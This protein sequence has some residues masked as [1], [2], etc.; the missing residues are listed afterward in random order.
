MKIST[1]EVTGLFE[2]Y[3]H[4]LEFNIPK[5]KQ[6]N[7]KASVIMMYGRNGI[8]KT[9]VLRMIEGL[10]TLDFDVFRSTKFVSAC[11]TFSNGNK[12]TVEC[13]FNE[14]NKDSL[15]VRYKDMEVKLNSKERGS[16]KNDEKEKQAFFVK[17]YNQ[18]LDNFTFEFI[19]TER[20]IKRNIKEQ[21][22]IEENANKG[23]AVQVKDQTTYL[24]DKV[25][26][27][28][29]DSQVNHSRYFQKTGLEL[30][31]RILIN[32]E[33][34]PKLNSKDLMN[35]IN[36]ITESE[37]KC[38]ID[39]LGLTKEK[40]NKKKLAEIISTSKRN[41]NKLT[42]ISSYIEVLESR[43][44]EIKNV[45]ERL[46]KFEN[47]LNGF[48]LD[49]TIAINQEGFILKSTNGDILKENIL[50]TGEYHLL[51]LTVLAL[52]T[53][54]KGTVIAIDEPEMSMHI[55]WQNNLVNALIQISSKAAPQ[56]IY[57]THSPDIAKN[58]VNSLN[59]TKYGS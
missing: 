12:I 52:C 28:V 27:F 36:S 48:L 14:N 21:M 34:H 35:R 22:L 51:Y 54:V 2:L 17:Q 56:M 6:I 10:M 13:I 31:D 45:A 47:L 4:T 25:K 38:Q 42:I 11:L 24:L 49:K 26:R 16:A 29:S 32:L 46:L 23:K 57:A 30:F 9:T 5:G 44:E 18:D 20:L 43:N 1:F 8:G 50:S 59:T 55:S 39:R 40:W 7:D 37:K 41:Q 15:L 58:Y 33:N 53:K 19:D 3:N